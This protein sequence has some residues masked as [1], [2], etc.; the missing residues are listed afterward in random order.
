MADD[1]IDLEAAKKI[2]KQLPM[3]S[4][5]P[6]SES[7]ILDTNLYPREA[8]LRACYWL[9]PEASFSIMS[10]GPAQITLSI[11]PLNGSELRAVTTKLQQA[12]ID[13]SIRVDVE[14]KTANIRDII[15]KTAF[16]EASGRKP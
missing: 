3:V 4:D 10:E 7:L 12:L 2:A 13:F 16:G 15:W 1:P 9:A 6:R 14:L 8:V 5:Q 11:A